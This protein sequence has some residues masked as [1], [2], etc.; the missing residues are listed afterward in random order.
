MAAAERA[1]VVASQEGEL[2]QLR[3]D[4]QRARTDGLALAEDRA[5]L[6][7]GRQAG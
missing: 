4:L 3:S 1:G 5:R 7:V 2:A 6:Q